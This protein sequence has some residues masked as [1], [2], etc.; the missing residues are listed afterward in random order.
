[1][2]GE[3]TSVRISH[4]SRYALINHAPDV[5]LR[6]RSPTHTYSYRKLLVG[7]ASLGPRSITD[8]LQIHGA[9]AGETRYQELFWRCGWELCGERL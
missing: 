4:D 2:D 8:S 3:T 5:G 6:L 1:M 9:E 7:N